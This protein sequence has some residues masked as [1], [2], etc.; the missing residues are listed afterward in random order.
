MEVRKYEATTIKEAVEMVKKDLGPDAIILSTKESQRHS[1]SHA[2]R[3]VIITA[4]VAE[5]TL[6]KK[7]VVEKNLSTK[8]LEKLSK[9]P[10]RVQRQF[11]DT[12][13]THIND[14]IVEKRRTLEARNYASIPEEDFQS[15]SLATVF[16]P[17]IKE[18]FTPTKIKQAY[19]TATAAPAPKVDTAK[20]DEL[21]NEIKRLQE[22][23]RNMNAIVK[24]TLTA[25]AS[26]YPGARLGVSQE[27]SAMFEKLTKEGLDEKMVA[28][29]MKNAQLQLKENVRKKGLLD[30]WV[31]KWMY[32]SVE[33][34][35]EKL[36]SRYHVFVGPR[37]VGKTS[38]LVKM[39]SH[40]VLKERKRV[41]I[42]SADNNKVGAVEQL[43]IYSHILNV[44][45]AVW[46]QG[47]DINVYLK[48]M[49]QVDYVLI[50]TEGQSLLQMK[51]I[52]NLKNYI[53]QNLGQIRVHLVLSAML[54]EEEMFSF[55]RRFK[56]IQFHD[57]ILTNIDQLRKHGIMISLQKQVPAPYFAFGLGP[58][59]PEDFEWASK[60]RVL[61]CIFKLS[62]TKGES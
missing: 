23:V 3:K 21:K 45:F 5:D 27:T 6:Q 30:A 24:P 25:S 47:E 13:Y 31:A 46:R 39:A 51:E 41:G 22:M 14:K 12:A 44:P 32:S 33:I 61:D 40:L 9:K 55:A 57:F 54:K 42:I 1:G 59:I 28:E 36:Q 20:I 17:K 50:D 18:N 56:S 43:R 62:N 60:E 8:D 4:A 7:R 15:E 52:D 11:I 29:L 49:E 37:G 53:P 35:K 48:Q 38:T 26:L 10:A 34:V 58:M 16:K 19:A 2:P